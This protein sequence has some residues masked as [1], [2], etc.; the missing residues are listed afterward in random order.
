MQTLSLKGFMEL[1]GHEAI[2][3]APY[4][5][6]V[7]V[8]TWGIGHTAAAGAP[9]PST[10]WN[11][12]ENVYDVLAVFRVDIAKYEA[13]VRAAFKRPMSQEQFD[14]AVSFDFN[15]G[16]ITYA[17][18]VKKF[19]AG[20]L[21]GAIA[22]IMSWTQPTSIKARRQ[23]EQMLFS[24]GIYSNAE[25]GTAYQTDG[26]GHIQWHSGKSIA[27]RPLL[28]PTAPNLSAGPLKAAL[29]T[30]PATKPVTPGASK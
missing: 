5:D 13:R 19:N 7:G 28:Q 14:A 24:K 4:F 27:L 22:A 18:W 21:S 23:K 8:L 20:D 6:S 29:P 12:P 11:R 15:T 9:L 17:T 26:K 30:S 1:I 25:H 3:P 16:A 2:V 10:L